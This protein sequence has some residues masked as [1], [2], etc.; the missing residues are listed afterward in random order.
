MEKRLIRE[1]PGLKEVLANI[2]AARHFTKTNDSVRI[3]VVVT[4]SDIDRKIFEKRLDEVNRCIFN[5]DESTL[6]ISLQEK[7]GAKTKEGNFLGT[8]LAYRSLKSAAADAGVPYRDFVT[9]I[10]M[11]F[12]RG[13]RMSPITQANRC[14]KPGIKVT[15]ANVEIGGKKTAFTAIE[16][17]LLYF[18][19]VVKYLEKKGFRGVLDKWGD[20][21]EIAS[22]DLTDIFDKDGSFAKYDIVKFISV[23]EITDELARQKEWVVFNDDG[24]MLSQLSRGDK[25]ALIERLKGL[26]I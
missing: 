1:T 21:T 10:G 19:P 20:E 6:V 15:P 17:A 8:L 2:E 11:L 25:K 5:R 14:S 7:T 26:G 24:D 12:G 23:M 4:G 18:T 9:L 22:V 3:V 16:E 13:E